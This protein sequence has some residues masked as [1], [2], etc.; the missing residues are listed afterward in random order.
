MPKEEDVIPDS[1]FL[2]TTNGTTEGVS[3][4]KSEEEEKPNLS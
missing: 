2:K 1:T 3:K 4:L